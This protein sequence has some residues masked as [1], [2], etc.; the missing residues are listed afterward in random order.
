MVPVHSTTTRP[1]NQR[2][3]GTLRPIQ[4]GQVYARGSVPVPLVGIPVLVVFAVCGQFLSV[5]GP[6]P[7][8]FLQNG[9][10]DIRCRDRLGWSAPK[11]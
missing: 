10:D 7:C 3:Q 1:K 5:L 6:D 8:D 2:G 4:G 11:I 9:V